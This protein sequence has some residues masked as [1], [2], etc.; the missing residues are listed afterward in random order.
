MSTE[1]VAQNI[2]SLIGEIGERM[3]LFKLYELTHTE[4]HLEIFKNYSDSGYDIGVRNSETDAKVKIEVK[5]RQHLF[6]N[7]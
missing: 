6:T 4:K 3:V 1:K 7:T 5:A 2:S